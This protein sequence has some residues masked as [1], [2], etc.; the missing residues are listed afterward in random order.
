MTDLA[1][2][3]R[4]RAHRPDLEKI[5]GGLKDFQR[6]TV[7]Y[8]FARMYTGHDPATRFLVADEVGLGKTL[9]ARGVIA[10]TVDALWEEVRRIDVVYICSNGDIARQN[11]RRLNVDE[12]EGFALASRI[13]L[14]PTQIHDLKRR[15]LN[16][17]SFTPRTSLDTRSAMGIAKERALLYWMLNKEWGLGRRAGPKNVLQGGSGL[18]P[19]RAELRWFNREGIDRTLTRAFHQRL[20]EHDRRE[21]RDGRPGLRER[22]DELSE[23]FAHSRLNERLPARDRE[24]RRQLVADLRAVLAASCVTALEPDLVI[25]DEFQRFRELLDPNPADAAGKLANE[26][27]SYS[28]IHR[29]RV[30]LLSATPYKMY[31]LAGEAAGDDHYRD[32]VRTLRF[33]FNDEQ[34][35]REVEELLENYRRAA[36]RAGENGDVNKL[37]ELKREIEA[38]L[39][40]VIARTE[41]LAVSDDR[42]GMLAP[43]PMD[44]L[45]LEPSDVRSYVRLQRISDELNQPDLLEYWKSAP[46]VFNFMD[47]Y[48]E[49]KAL[50]EALKDDTREPALRAPINAAVGRG[51]LPWSSVERYDKVDR[52]NPRLR[53]LGD[54]LIESGGWRQL[55]VTPALPYYRLR[56]PFGPARGGVHTKQ[57]VFSSWAV[58][59]K[60]SAALLTFE[61]ERAMFRSH[62]DSPM[63]TSEARERRARPLEFRRRAGDLASLPVLGL[64]YG[65][66]VFARE[67]DPLEIALGLREDGRTPTLAAVV[68]VA[69]RRAHELIGELISRAPR[70]GRPDG[71]WYWAAPMLSDLARSP[72]A[73]EAW[74]TDSK[75][76][77]TGDRSARPADGDAAVD[78]H[79]DFA[80]Q[81]L[82]D[83][84]AGGSP[85]GRPPD[86]LDRVL[87]LQAIAGPGTTALRAL[88]RVT[89]FTHLE[90]QHLRA[91]ATRIATGLRTLFNVPEAVAMMRGLDHREPYWL[92]VLEYAANGCLQGVLDEYCHVLLEAQGLI[93][94]DPA[95]IEAT[96]PRAIER[97]LSLRPARLAVDDI[98]VVDGRARTERRHMRAR[99]ATRF[100]VDERSDEGGETTRADA[101]RNAFNSP[102]WPF[103]L[104]STSIGQEGLDFHLYCHAVTHWNVPANPVDLEQRE[105]RVHRYKGHAVRKNI[106]RRYGLGAVSDPTKDPWTILF[107]QARRDRDPGAT[108][109][110]PFWVYPIEG[111]A[112]IER[113]VPALPMSRDLERYESLRRSLAIY[114][115]AFGQP[116]QDDL[117][118]F[119]LSRMPLEQ[120]RTIADELRIDLAPPTDVSLTSDSRDIGSVPMGIGVP[121]RSRYS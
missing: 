73:T 60:A 87:A 119:L 59:P 62:E 58:V 27:F 35:T 16:F 45:R 56:R 98:S 71:S 91:G 37:R 43:I 61:A 2:A 75:V 110:V 18:R 10:R 30:L 104:V 109:L 11:I 34:R 19:F 51:L 116:R 40:L 63:N 42:D 77:L 64:M 111:G 81:L 21:K 28:D 3:G 88:A 49:K 70:H 74:F 78:E 101:V 48:V 36:L 38:R 83:V 22:F 41:R 120:A 32:F 90:D 72:A 13:T 80:W 108:D 12:D 94:P 103:V 96:V 79:I 85:L 97:A 53:R 5:L 24:D 65:S 100:G 114:R 6:R 121:T 44:D 29:V 46:Y 105:G 17:I 57:L 66:P 4:V 93:D 8:V 31:T 1:R 26:L 82:S 89:G 67:V 106:A 39:R 68:D 117:I 23:R 95:R 118:A 15:K 54:R 9:V 112:M 25:L 84:R 47:E 107:E 33:L 55:W 99:F 92:R 20:V 69:Q 52:A 50:R 115:M 102:F 113:H 76:I 14:L 86:D 7:D